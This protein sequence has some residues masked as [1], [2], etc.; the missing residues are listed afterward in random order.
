MSRR[1]QPAGLAGLAFSSPR[2][3]GSASQPRGFCFELTLFY[4]ATFSRWD[5]PTFA[6]SGVTAEEGVTLPS[7]L[8][9]LWTADNIFDALYISK[10]PWAGAL[11]LVLTLS[12]KHSS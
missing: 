3:V 7:P 4:G 8:V 6:I 10:L 2:A 12:R 9:L 5:S 11:P 1:L